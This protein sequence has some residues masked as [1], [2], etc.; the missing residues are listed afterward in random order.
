MVYHDD[1]EMEVCD[2]DGRCREVAEGGEADERWVVQK[3]ERRYRVMKDPVS[4]R[5]RML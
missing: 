1:A 5:E 3:Y 4:G 2:K